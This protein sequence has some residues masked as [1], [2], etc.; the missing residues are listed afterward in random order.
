MGA[1][2]ADEEKVER[3]IDAVVHEAQR[4]RR[5]RKQRYGD[6]DEREYAARHFAGDRQHSPHQ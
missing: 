5:E 4:L 2:E 1:E 3:E 6:S